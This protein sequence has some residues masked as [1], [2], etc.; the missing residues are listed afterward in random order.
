MARLESEYRTGLIQRIQRRWPESV[1]LPT[2]PSRQQGIL[3][4]IVLI[5]CRWAML[6]LKRASNSRRRPN[7]PY[8][9]EK[10]NNMS[11]AAFICPENEDEV[12]DE[13]QSTLGV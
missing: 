7:Q 3:D 5:G 11:F 13:L 10:F 6:E 2:D 4:I 8:F 1:I 9:V 12:L